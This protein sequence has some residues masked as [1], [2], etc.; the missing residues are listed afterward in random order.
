MPA[1]PALGSVFLFPWFHLEV[2]PGM[3]AVNNSGCYIQTQ[4]QLVENT[5]RVFL[6]VISVPRTS[7]ADVFSV[8][9]IA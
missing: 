6:G 3:A 8:T 5:G 9:M 2:T 7:S 1:P 4:Q